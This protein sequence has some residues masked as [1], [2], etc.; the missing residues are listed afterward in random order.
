MADWEN[1][2]AENILKCGEAAGVLLLFYLLYLSFLPYTCYIDRYRT[3]H[4]RKNYVAEIDES[5]NMLE[6]GSRTLS[7]EELLSATTQKVRF[8]LA[9]ENVHRYHGFKARIHSMGYIWCS[10]CNARKKSFLNV[11]TKLGEGESE[12]LIAVTFGAGNLIRT[13]F[14]TKADPVVCVL[15]F[16]KVTND[17]LPYARTEMMIDRQDPNFRRRIVL[18]VPKD[19]TIRILVV[20]TDDDHHEGL[21]EYVDPVTNEIVLTQRPVPMEKVVKMK[22]ELW[23]SAQAEHDWVALTSLKLDPFTAVQ[24]LTTLL[25]VFV[26]ETAVVAFMFGDPNEDTDTPGLIQDLAV[27]VW[28]AV[29][30][31]PVTIPFATLFRKSGPVNIAYTVIDEALVK[32]QLTRLQHLRSRLTLQWIEPSPGTLSEAIKRSDSYA[33][34]KQMKHLGFSENDDSFRVDLS[35][36]SNYRKRKILLR[37]HTK[38]D[39]LEQVASKFPPFHHGFLQPILERK[40]SLAWAEAP[41]SKAAYHFES[42]GGLLGSPEV[43]LSRL[44]TVVDVIDNMDVPPL[45]EAEVD[46]DSDIA[47]IIKDTTRSKL[48][49]CLYKCLG[50]YGRRKRRWRTAP[51][52]QS[53][54]STNVA[55]KAEKGAEELKKA[56]SVKFNSIDAKLRERSRRVFIILSL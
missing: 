33:V 40:P 27:A 43:P 17:Y 54:K 44:S 10:C 6:L 13:D 42:P 30:L 12:G 34:R 11:S 53:S 5:F 48:S 41:N 16:D 37:L 9:H 24:R 18:R 56:A 3:R 55:Q 26:T 4:F 36:S 15:L 49:K 21:V 23:N 38:T 52:S 8:D 20:I 14:A 39:P 7:F 46:E 22:R 35:K 31:I 2:T 19:K 50:L 29:I 28:T 45:L 51:N 25:C 32:S 47:A 1:L